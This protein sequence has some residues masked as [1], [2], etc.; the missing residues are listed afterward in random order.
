MRPR[1]AVA[2][3]GLRAIAPPK[4]GAIMVFGKR[5]DRILLA[6]WV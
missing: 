5:E 6:G 3:I 1:T 2:T 4:T